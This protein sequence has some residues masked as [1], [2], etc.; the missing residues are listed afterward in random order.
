[1]AKTRTENEASC[2][3]VTET[4]SSGLPG[5]KAMTVRFRW[6]ITLNAA[7]A[8]SLATG[9]RP[10]AAEND[11][12]R[13]V[14]R[15]LVVFGD[16]LADTGNASRATFGLQPG[17]SYFAGRFSNGPV[18]TDL[19]ARGLGLGELAP[20]ARG[21]T[22]F[23]FAG[24]RATGTPGL[25]GL[26]IEDVDEQVDEFLARHPVTAQSL[27]VMFAGANDLV[28]VTEAAAPGLQPGT[29]DYDS[30]LIVSNPNFHLFWDDFHPT[31]AAHAIVAQRALDI[32][33]A[34]PEPDGWLRVLLA[35]ALALPSVGESATRSPERTS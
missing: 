17:P 27:V 3:A 15:Q 26:F 12:D 19:L 14:Y 11:H 34:V 20:S 18:F 10:F 32:V 33:T 22:N 31:A 28:N 9:G 24:A 8:L 1:M 13:R 16:S 2:P 21:G 7:I 6:Q 30:S 23:A 25:P 35:C 4:L 5:D 29:V